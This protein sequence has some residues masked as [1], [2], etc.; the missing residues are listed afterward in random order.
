MSVFVALFGSVR[1]KIYFDLCVLQHH[2]FGLLSAADAAREN[3][4]DRVTAT[5]PAGFQCNNQ[6]FFDL[7]YLRTRF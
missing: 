5:N 3:G 1:A 6:T 7:S 4:Y 2:A